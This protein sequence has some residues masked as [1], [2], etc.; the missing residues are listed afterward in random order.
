[1][2]GNKQVR[3]YVNVLSQYVWFAL[4]ISTFTA[5]LSKPAW[6]IAQ[7]FYLLNAGIKIAERT[8]TT[9]VQAAHMNGMHEPYRNT[10]S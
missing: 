5:I 3:Q 7:L 8:S 2:D 9:C 10:Q 4:K 6:Q 1:M